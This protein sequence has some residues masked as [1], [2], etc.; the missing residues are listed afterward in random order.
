MR[1]VKALVLSLP[2][3]GMTVSGVSAVLALNAVSAAP[4]FAADKK[5]GEKQVGAK[6]G[7]PLKEALDLANGG[8]LKD[9][10]AKAQEAAAV[11]GKTPFEEYKINEVIAFIAV[12]LSDYGTAAKAYEATLQ[13]GEL[14]ADQAKERLNQLTKMYYQLNN[15]PKAIQYGSQYLKDGGTDLMAAVLVAQSYYQQKDNERAIEASQA[16]IKMANQ[17]GQ[18]VK[19]EWLQLLMNCQIRADK[20]DEAIKTL[21]LLLDKYPSQQYWNSRLNYAQTHGGSSDRK[22]LE[23]YRLKFLLGVMKDSEYVEMAQ[24]AMALGFPGDAKAVLDK[25]FSSKVL[26]VGA[27]KDRENR[28]YNLAQTNAAN[29]QKGLVGFEKE[30]S[31]AAGG[32]SDIKL[33]EAYASYGNYEKAVE[34]M[35]RGLKKGSVKAEDEAHL[36]LGIALANLKRNSEAVAEFKAVPAD[37]KL[38]D[39][40]HLWIIHIGNKS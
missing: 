8:K 12:K 7:K 18:P 14:P 13:S 36:Q 39:V 25:G 40:A 3:I 19:E 11:S 33:G 4:A 16:L 35:K 2:A 23:I 17:S 9:A 15:Y 22:N 38:A 6:V 24:L 32:D 20:E 21:D 26:G 30:A 37:S 31:A 28:L 5:G 1:I 34:A 29:D 10:M 27:S